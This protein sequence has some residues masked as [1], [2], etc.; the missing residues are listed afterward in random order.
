MT[1]RIKLARTRVAVVV[2]LLGVGVLVAVT[3]TQQADSESGA[4]V[5]TAWG[6]PDLQGVWSVPFGHPL[7]RDPKYG[8]RE[9]LT[10]A[11]RAELMVQRSKQRTRDDRVFER[12]SEQ[13]VNGGYNIAF[14][15]RAPAGRFTS[16]IVDPPD[17]RVPPMTPDAKRR[18]TMESEFALAL[19]QATT[20]CRDKL[21]NCPGGEYGPVSPRYG[22]VPPFY[23]AASIGTG[24]LN[25]AYGPEDMDLRTRCLYPPL[26]NY[27]GL[28]FRIRIV[29]SKKAVSIFY[30]GSQGTN[31]SRV[32]PI[33]DEPHLPP[34]VR[35]WGG[36][37]RGRWEGDNLVVDVTNFDPR[38]VFPKTQYIGAMGG[39]KEN[40]HLI[41]KYRRVDE[42]TLLYH[43][44]ID[45]PSAWTKPWTI[46][47][48]FVRTDDQQNDIFY[49]P[50][51][52]EGNYSLINS[53][54]GA[55]V[56][57]KAFAE[58][59]GPDP[60]TMCISTCGGDR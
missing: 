3:A 32:I 9:I 15:P 26:P 30:E 27:S 16:L 46:R 57:E 43:V 4:T 35:L 52:H 36:D 41:E 44:T 55:R 1:R 34:Q 33:T 20:T 24:G 48:E 28:E 22:E 5:E 29:Q 11:E 7:Q 38:N 40:L 58:G 23:V 17:G 59:K 50:R 49:E 19:L 54:S 60:A 25:R 39:S 10:E 56:A 51:C 13:D 42:T 45:D 14:T 21:P 47:Q 8:D 53:L 31:W 37:S 18:G 2:V 6:D 12:G